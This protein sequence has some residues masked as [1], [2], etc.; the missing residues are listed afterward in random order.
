MFVFL[1]L[2]LGSQYS[3]LAKFFPNLSR[4][5]AEPKVSVDAVEQIGDVSSNDKPIE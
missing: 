3:D 2:S 5:D 4:L 1:K